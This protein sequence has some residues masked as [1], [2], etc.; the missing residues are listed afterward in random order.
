MIIHIALFDNNNIVMQQPPC[1]ISPSRFSE[2][3]KHGKHPVLSPPPLSDYTSG[4]YAPTK[5]YIRCNSNGSTLVILY[6][7]TVKY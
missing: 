6:L 3:V 4:L 2:R 7:G 5:L 1:E